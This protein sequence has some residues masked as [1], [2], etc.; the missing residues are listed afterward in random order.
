MTRPAIEP[1]DLVGGM[2][3]WDA[4]LRD[5]LTAIAKAPFP[6]V[7]YANLAAFPAAG[8]YDGCLAIA[9]DTGKLHFSKAST[10]REV[11]LV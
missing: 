3:A 9:T 11:Q 8:S 7:A 6:P 4:L 5:I 10:W 1:A 2:E